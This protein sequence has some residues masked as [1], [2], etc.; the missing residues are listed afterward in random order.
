VVLDTTS[1]TI[2]V[3]K[4]NEVYELSDELRDRLHAAIM[5]KCNTKIAAQAETPKPKIS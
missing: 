3:Y 5:A 4:D 1:Q 2:A